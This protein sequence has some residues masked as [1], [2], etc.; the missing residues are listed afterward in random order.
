[1]SLLHEIDYE[2]IMTLEKPSKKK[3]LKNKLETHTAQRQ[4]FTWFTFSL[5][6]W[7]AMRIRRNFTSKFKEYKMM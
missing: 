4:K 5:P 1:M 7:I 3:K 2:N 6:S